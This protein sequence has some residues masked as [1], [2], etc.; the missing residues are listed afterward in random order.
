[1]A[2]RGRRE[3]APPAGPPRTGRDLARQVLGRVERDGAF[4]NRAL[5]AALDRASELSAPDRALATELVYGVLRRRARLDRALDAVADRGL[6]V[7]SDVRNVLRVGAY[8]LLFLD[9]IPSYAAVNDTV[10]AMKRQHG[11]RMGGLANALLRRVAERGEPPLPDPK[12]DA[13]AFLVDGCGFPDWLARLCLRDLG[14]ERAVALATASGEAAPLALRA[15]RL[16]GITRDALERTLAAERPGAALAA[17]AVAPDALLA[18]GL[19]APG[20]TEAF[21]AG[22]FAIEDVGAQLVAELCGAA[23]GE[24]ILDACAGLGG[25]TA[26]LAA[27]AGNEASIDALDLSDAKLRQAGEQWARL[28]TSGIAA[29]AADL[30]KDFPASSP[31]YHRVLLDAP[32]SGLGVLR[33]HPEVLFRRSEAD[34]TLLAATQRRMLDVVAP[35]VEPGG[36]LVY[37][38]CTFD[39]AEGEE[40]VGAFLTAHPEFRP[41]PPPEGTA[42]P[43]RRLVAAPEAPHL[44]RLWPD[45]D[46]ADA[47]FAARLQRSA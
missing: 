28:R 45:R 38:V 34:L 22:A 7:P 6:K 26:H 14:D 4:A 47:F 17:S 33:R 44:I 30:T 9:R 15:N 37:A 8:Q 23:P 42:V 25:K 13:R 10:E 31:R 1:M 24:R 39:R 35:L 3:N 19:D 11:A 36:L 43:W 5:A 18:R 20:T 40:V 27:L 2:E 32:C 12:R 41:A 29:R 46:D 21:A 16:A